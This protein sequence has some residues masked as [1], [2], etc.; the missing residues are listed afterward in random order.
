MKWPWKSPGTLLV[1]LGL[2]PASATGISHPVS[3]QDPLP[4]LKCHCLQQPREALGVSAV[5]QN[6]FGAV[7][8][9]SSVLEGIAGAQA[10]FVPPLCSPHTGEIQLWISALQGIRLCSNPCSNRPSRG[11]RLPRKAD[12]C[13][14]S[15]NIHSFCNLLQARLLSVW[16]KMIPCSNSSFLPQLS[17]FS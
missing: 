15:Q 12:E 11:L 14:A 10:V 9:I 5:L 7:P 8:H 16:C 3:R 1:M 13:S 17:F 6:L 2:T 4:S